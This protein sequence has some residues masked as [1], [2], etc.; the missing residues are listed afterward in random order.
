MTTHISL[1][2]RCKKKVAMAA[3]YGGAKSSEIQDFESRR[4]RDYAAETA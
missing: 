4:K 3:L 1:L 2:R